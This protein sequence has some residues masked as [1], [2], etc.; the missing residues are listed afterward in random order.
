[1]QGDTGIMDIEKEKANDKSLLRKLVQ[2]HREQAEHGGAD[3]EFHERASV[4]LAYKADIELELMKLE[5]S[6]LKDQLGQAV[7]IIEET[8]RRD[9]R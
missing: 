1:M 4:L 7:L 5:N 3:R 6:R 2:W 8:K 9:D